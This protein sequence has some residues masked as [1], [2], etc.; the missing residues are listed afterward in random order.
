MELKDYQLKG[1]EFLTKNKS[2]ILADD[3]GLGKTV[4]TIKAIEK[5][6][7]NK[8]L[9]ICPKSIKKQWREEIKKWSPSLSSSTIV[10]EGDRKKREMLWQ[11]P[12]KIKIINYELLRMEDFKFIYKDWWDLIVCD[13]ITRIKNFRA[14]TT[15]LLWKLRD[16]AK[17]RWGLTG[18]PIENYPVELYNIFR[19]INPFVFGKW[20]NFKFYFL[21][22]EMKNFY[23]KMV[24]KIVG[25]K[26]LELLKFKIA[27]YVLRRRRSEVLNDLPPIVVEERYVELTPFQNK[28]YNIIKFHAEELINKE[29]SALGDFNLA[30]I[31]CDTPLA[32]KSS[33]T[34]VSSLDLGDD[35]NSEK[36][37]ELKFILEESLVNNNQAVIFTE[38]YEVLVLIKKF[39]EEL[40]YKVSVFHGGL[41]EEERKR[42]EE[43]FLNK[44]TQIIISTQAGGWGMNW[45]NAN[46]LI[47]FD[48]PLNPAKL[49][50]RIGR[51]YRMGQQN[52]VVVFDL[53]TKDSVEERV[54]E[55]LNI[56]LNYIEEVFG[57]KEEKRIEIDNSLIR[58]LL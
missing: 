36:F 7:L 46:I 43:K 4:Q 41:S 11:T 25:Y 39:L 10:I 24:E 32:L 21:I 44:Q 31:V 13:E 12:S 19:F 51:V 42:E 29:M 35:Y 30:R 3:V 48:T 8:I 57:N 40:G 18:T 34:W 1:V 33:P 49:Y 26:N 52:K 37:E 53:I 14:K 20:E 47:N 56:K 9:I 50:Q 22:T 17:Y 5:L 2:A 27:P 45:Q 28:I 15:R 58:R 6:N 16:R 23:G 38:W 54:R 55:I